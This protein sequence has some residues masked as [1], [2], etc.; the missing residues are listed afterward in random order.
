MYK[1]IRKEKGTDETLH[2]FIN[3][4]TV[5]LKNVQRNKEKEKGEFT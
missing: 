4:H 2:N 1:G 3:K 5:N